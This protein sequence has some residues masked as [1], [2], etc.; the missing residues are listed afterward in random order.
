M[1]SSNFDTSPATVIRRMENQIG[2][3][4]ILIGVGHAVNSTVLSQLA[5]AP[6][7]LYAIAVDNFSD[8]LYLQFRLPTLVG[9]IPR[10]QILTSQLRTSSMVIGQYYTVLLDINKEAAAQDVIISFALSC[11]SCPVF[12]SLKEP[13]PTIENSVRAI[14]AHYNYLNTNYAVYYFM[15]PKN[16]RRFFCSFLANV[17]GV[18]YGRFDVFP[19]LA[20]MSNVG[21]GA[22]SLDLASVIG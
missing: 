2:M 13:N 3:T 15:V 9:E 1:I 16:T 4:V 14:V 5:S 12:A 22:T 8:L 20:M 10:A 6:Q 7:N 17:A 18:S 21:G 11:Y 19:V